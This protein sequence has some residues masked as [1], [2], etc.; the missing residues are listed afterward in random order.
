MS[1]LLMSWRWCKWFEDYYDGGDVEEDDDDDDDDD[2]Y[3]TF[4][5]PYLW[6]NLTHH[7]IHLTHRWN[8][9]NESNDANDIC[10]Y[11]DHRRSVDC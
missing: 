11:Y 10:H 7:N 3:Y 9:F 4:N 1:M 6:I 5:V 2:S 8:N